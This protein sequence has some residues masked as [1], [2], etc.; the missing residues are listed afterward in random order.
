MRIQELTNNRQIAATSDF[1]TGIL[2]AYT[3]FK[4]RTGENLLDL[5]GR[6]IPPDH[7]LADGGVRINRMLRHADEIFSPDPP[8]MRLS[9]SVENGVLVIRR[10][11]AADPAKVAE[12]VEGKRVRRVY[13]RGVH[14][15]RR[16]YT[17]D[18]GGVS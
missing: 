8:P 9:V 2:D 18:F 1:L 3:D 16:C 13:T 14:G 12:A 6:D 11:R 4:A 7:E 17:P 10:I 15:G 5:A